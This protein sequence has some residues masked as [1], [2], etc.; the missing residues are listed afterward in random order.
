MRRFLALLC[1]ALCG[2]AVATGLATLS[3]PMEARPS[4]VAA[5]AVTVVFRARENRVDGRESGEVVVGQTVVLTIRAPLGDL[6]AYERAIIAAK[7]LNG[8]VDDYGP[9]LNLALGA[10]ED[11]VFVRAETARVV[12]VDDETARLNQSTVQ[13]LGQRW[14][15]NIRQVLTNPPTEPAPPTAGDP[16]LRDPAPGTPELAG[17]GPGRP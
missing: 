12:T 11:R 13:D 7:R 3:E 5:P 14:I 8:A 2:A 15:V 4:A 16:A 10:E 9:Q 17:P 1:S 6:S